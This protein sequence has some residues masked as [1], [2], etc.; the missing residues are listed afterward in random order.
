MDQSCPPMPM[1]KDGLG[2][3]LELLLYRPELLVG[4][5]EAT[6][7]ADLGLQKAV[8]VSYFFSRGASFLTLTLKLEIVL[9]IISV[10]LVSSRPCFSLYYL[11]AFVSIFCWDALIIK[12][13]SYSAVT[14]T[15]TSSSS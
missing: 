5:V 4:V 3:T 6:V 11:R 12:K 14:S 1:K 8:N 7:K 2:F 15:K 13:F 10:G 9:A